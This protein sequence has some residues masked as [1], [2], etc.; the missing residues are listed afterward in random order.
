MAIK[1]E[2]TRVHGL[3]DAR[4]FHQVTRS[5]AAANRLWGE[6]YAMLHS[7]ALLDRPI[8]WRLLKQFQQC[9][10]SPPPMGYCRREI[11]RLDEFTAVEFTATRH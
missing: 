3:G 1:Y 7:A 9:E 5:D 6:I 4:E 2:I 10:I 8:A 11:F